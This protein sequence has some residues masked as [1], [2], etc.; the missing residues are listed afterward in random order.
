MRK[1][2]IAMAAV[3][4]LACLTGGAS[5]ASLV[6][7][8]MSTS[9]QPIDWYC[10]P[11]CQHRQWERRRWEQQ[12]WLDSQRWRHRQYYGYGYNRGYG[13]NP[14]YGYRGYGYNPGYGYYRW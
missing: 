10:G 3:T 8:D 2:M 11:R 7:P 4:G 6:A 14:G 1:S 13:Y 5:A 12:R 9:V